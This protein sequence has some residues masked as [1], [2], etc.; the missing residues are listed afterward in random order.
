MRKGS[1]ST[2]KDVLALGRALVEELELEP[3]VD[4]LSRWMAHHVAELIRAAD[5]AGPDD[6]AEKLEACVSTILLLWDRKHQLPNGRRPFEDF[7]PILRALENLDPDNVS[8][9]YY[10]E[11]Q[12]EAGRAKLSAKAKELFTVVEGLD[13]SA[14]MLIRHFLVEAAKTSLKKSEK[15]IKLAEAAGLE[16]QRSSGVIRFLEKERRFL[17]EEPS[18]VERKVLEDRIKR[19]EAFVTYASLLAAELRQKLGQAVKS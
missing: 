9:R 5:E 12:A 7:D 1:S 19:L 14:R 11:A 4:T 2:A 3:G 6:R 16:D 17:E 10:R 15:W 8:P 13:Y 18:E